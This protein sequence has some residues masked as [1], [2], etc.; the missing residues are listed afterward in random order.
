M[1]FFR[2]RHT[3][4]PSR[5]LEPWLFAIARNVAAM[6]PQIMRAVTGRARTSSN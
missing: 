4:Q 2:A 1:A 3:Y 5:P 6:W